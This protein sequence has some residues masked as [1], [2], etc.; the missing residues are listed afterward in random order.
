MNVEAC[1]M[2]Q[3][4]LDDEVRERFAAAAPDSEELEA[5]LRNC[6]RD[7]LILEGQSRGTALAGLEHLARLLRIATEEA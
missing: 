6:M 1:E 5:K 3:E 4:K 7:C 2:L